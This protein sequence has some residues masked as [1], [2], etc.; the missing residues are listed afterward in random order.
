MPVDIHHHTIEQDNRAAAE[1]WGNRLG[2]RVTNAAKR[3]APVDEGTLRASI[4]YTLEWSAGS[5]HITIGS[6]LDYAEYFHTGTGIYGPKATPIVPVTRKALKFRWEPT[7]PGAKKKLPKE[8]R[9]WFF[10]TS[11]KGIEPDPFLIDALKE[12][13]GVIDT[14]R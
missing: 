1:R 14:L 5:C 3:R 6:P 12:V 4:D 8:Q 7:G 10:A 11:V 2:R 9:G 13:M